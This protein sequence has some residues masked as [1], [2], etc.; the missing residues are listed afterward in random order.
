M[1]LFARKVG[2]RRKKL[3]EEINTKDEVELS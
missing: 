2:R 3:L 1:L